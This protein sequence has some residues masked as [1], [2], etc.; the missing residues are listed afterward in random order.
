M[1]KLVIIAGAAAE[2]GS[3]YCKEIISQNIDCI[4]V[5][6]N[7]AMVFDSPYLNVIVCRLDV[8]KDIE[9]KFSAIN[10]DIYD[11]VIYL[12]AIGTDAFEPRGYPTIRP[13]ETIPPIV[14]DANVNSFKYLF[15]YCI[16][17]IKDIRHSTG[18]KISFKT[19]IIG[20]V[21]DKY[22]PFVIESFCEAKFILRQYIQ[23][24]VSLYSEWCSGLSINITSTNIK[25]AFRVRPYADTTYWLTPQ[26]VV[27]GSMHN[28]LSDD[29]GY[30][31]MDII[32]KDPNFVPSYYENNDLLYEKW[33]KETGIK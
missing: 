1:K 28:L 19:A 2:I 31:E 20:G 7:T 32:K 17:R 33:S 6:R 16:K 30:K 18:K 27:D 9:E 29:L 4:A 13:L 15:R 12:H 3:S 10:F 11:S 26:E 14:Y 22:T 24:S 8:E 5:I 23:S 25:G 21:P